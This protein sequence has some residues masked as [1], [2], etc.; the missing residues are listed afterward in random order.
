MLV[1]LLNPHGKRKRYQHCTNTLRTQ[2][3]FSP[4]KAACLKEN[5]SCVAKM[6][7]TLL[8]THESRVAPGFPLPVSFRH[9]HSLSFEKLG[10]PRAT[11]SIRFFAAILRAEI[12]LQ[13]LGYEVPCSGNFIQFSWSLF[14]WISSIWDY[15]PNLA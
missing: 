12:Q 13:Q 4:K 6:L 1:S 14:F 7:V 3:T 5:V 11:K 2:L 8:V 15:A 10:R 9:I